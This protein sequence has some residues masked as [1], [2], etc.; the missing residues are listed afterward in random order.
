M[1]LAYDAAD[2][3]ARVIAERVLLNARDAGITLQLTSA[4]S[5]LRLVRMNLASSDP[6]VALNELAQSLRLPAPKFGS[7]SVTDLYAAEKALLQSHHVIPLLHVRGAIALRPNV[8][9]W[10]MLPDGSW[11]LRNIWLGAEKP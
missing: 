3:I 5:D 2:P 8:R 7:G 4:N 6:H 10:R 11:Q 9:D 1:T